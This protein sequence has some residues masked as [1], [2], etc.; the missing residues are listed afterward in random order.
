M[1]AGD[2]VEGAAAARRVGEPGIA[3]AH[4]V[5]HRGAHG[6]ARIA[7]GRRVVD[8]R[9]QFELRMVGAHAGIIGAGLLE[10]A[11][12]ELVAGQRLHFVRLGDRILAFGVLLELAGVDA[13]DAD[14][15][16]NVVAIHQFHLEEDEL[17]TRANRTRSGTSVRR[18][19]RIPCPA[20]R[21][22]EA[23]GT[24]VRRWRRSRVARA[25]CGVASCQVWLGPAA[26]GQRLICK[27]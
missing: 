7:V 17:G 13:E 23:A 21:C 24:P 11:R 26:S 3:R 14:V 4:D 10:D 19:E 16:R 2:A 20:A 5:V 27:R 8:A 9:A 15:D 6:L 25:R 18:R 12:R 1:H 22:R